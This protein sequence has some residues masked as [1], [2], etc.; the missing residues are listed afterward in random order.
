M[1]IMATVF[2]VFIF[3]FSHVALALDKAK[4]IKVRGEVTKLLPGSLDAAKVVQGEFIPEDTSLLTKDGSFV[5]LVYEDGHIIS[6]GAN[7]KMVLTKLSQSKNQILTVLKGQLRVLVDNKKESD[8]TQFYVRTRTAAMGVRGTDFSAIYGAETGTTALITYKGEVL[9]AK[10]DPR[11]KGT[12]SFQSIERGDDG[13][14]EYKEAIEPARETLDEEMERALKNRPTVVKAGQYSGVFEYLPVSTAPVKLNPVQF[15]ALYEN[16][17]L[18]EYD[19]SNRQRTD[20]T[21]FS[22]KTL[23]QAPQEI[24][25]EGISDQQKE[26]F[27]PRAGGLVDL[28]SGLYLSPDSGKIDSER[29]VYLVEKIGNVD[30]RT[31]QFILPDGVQFD[32]HKGHVLIDEKQKDQK[33]L[34]L[35]ALLNEQGHIGP[36]RDMKSDAVALKSAFSREELYKKMQFIFSLRSFSQSLDL[37]KNTYENNRSLESQQANGFNLIWREAGEGS[38]RSFFNINYYNVNFNG[39]GGN[40][41][42]QAKSLFGIGLGVSHFFAEKI[43]GHVRLGLDRELFGQYRQPV[44]SILRE[45]EKVTLSKILFGAKAD[46]YQ[47]GNFSLDALVE[48][49]TN[50][51]K[52]KSEL[53]VKSGLIRNISLGV[54]YLLRKENVLRVEIFSEN[55]KLDVSNGIFSSEQEI[56]RKGIIFGH[57]WIF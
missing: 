2:L 56:D 8:H 13:R 35:A 10:M 11:K 25:I 55:L 4:V 27:A 15:E 39:G 20:P 23:Y 54:A 31:G 3:C 30:A 18:V 38:W 40:F 47:W 9:M 17:D 28:E 57:E 16:K 45:I 34:A 48:L 19:R 6:I 37:T 14:P 26:I 51:D 5:R 52:A 32:A 42:Q 21:Q 22:G 12:T 7:S 41:S 43:E 1:N 50:F 46:I 49:G 33:L 36:M 29:G 44:S 53:R 24:P